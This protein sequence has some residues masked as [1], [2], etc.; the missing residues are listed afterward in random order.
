LLKL[1]NGATWDFARSAIVVKTAVKTGLL[2]VL[3]MVVYKAAAETMVDGDATVLTCLQDGSLRVAETRSPVCEDN[4][5]GVEANVMRPLAVNTYCWTGVMSAAL[6]A[7]HILKASPG[8]I[9]SLSV[10]LDS[11]AAS[12]TYYIQI[13]NSAT[14]PAEGAVTHIRTPYKVQ[15]VVGL[16]D[17]IELDFTDNGFYGSAGIV[18]VL[19]TTEFTKT[20]AGAYLSMDARI[21]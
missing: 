20:I 2:N 5:N 8:C 11:T 17:I 4:T 13:L 3:G 14:L 16:D 12:A 9:R 15:H 21:I 1:Y 10:R 19:S 7:S 6:E 18:V